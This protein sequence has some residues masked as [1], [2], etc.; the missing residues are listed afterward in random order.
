MPKYL[1]RRGAGAYG[2]ADGAEDVESGACSFCTENWKLATFTV[3]N[4]IANVSY[5][6]SSQL[7]AS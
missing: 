4:L 2:L 1:K 7:S 3:V 6:T 5:T